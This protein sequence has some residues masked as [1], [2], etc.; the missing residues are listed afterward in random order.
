[1]TREPAPLTVR[2]PAFL[3][4]QFVVLA[5]VVPPALL[6]GSVTVAELL[7][8]TQERDSIFLIL[9]AVAFAYHFIFEWLLGQTLGKAI[10]GLE[11]VGSNRRDLTA[12]ESL[13]RNALRGIDGLGA[14][15]VAVLV[16]LVRGD[17]KRIGDVA[18]DSLVIKKQ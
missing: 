10:F 16:I 14:W 15:G 17:G 11:V 18:A 6:V 5:L 7:A 2:T 9:M 4:D 3:I 1:M 12:L 13:L 8:S